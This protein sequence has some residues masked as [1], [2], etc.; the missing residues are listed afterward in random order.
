MLHQR[1]LAGDGDGVNH[2]RAKL[3]FGGSKVEGGGVH[4][5]VPFER[6][7]CISAHS[8]ND[9]CHCAFCD[10]FAFIEGSAFADA[11]D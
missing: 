4:G 11:F 10:A 3:V 7:A 8:A 2:E 9:S 5:P 6:A 1:G